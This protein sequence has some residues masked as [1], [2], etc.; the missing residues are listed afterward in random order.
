MKQVTLKA[1]PRGSAQHRNNS[2]KAEFTLAQEL[3]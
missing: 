3:G 1:D 2:E